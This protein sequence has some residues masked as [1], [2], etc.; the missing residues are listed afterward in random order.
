VK[1]PG[2]T[3]VVSMPSDATSQAIDSA[4]ASKAALAAAFCRRI[5]GS[6]ARL[7][8]KGPTVLVS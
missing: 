6:T 7:T 3:I 1:T 5:A 4:K 2:W 8:R